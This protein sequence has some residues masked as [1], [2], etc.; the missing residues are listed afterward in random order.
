MES[1]SEN[2]DTQRISIDRMLTVEKHRITHKQAEYE[3]TNLL[4]L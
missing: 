2:K 1:E 4:M 3:V